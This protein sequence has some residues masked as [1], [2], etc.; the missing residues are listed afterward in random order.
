MK[1]IDNNVF[2]SFLEE[3]IAAGKTV[4][5][6]A[7]GSSMLPFITEDDI[8]YL[9]PFNKTELKK[10]DIILFKYNNNYLLHRII[11]KKNT[12]LLI[13]GDAVANYREKIKIDDVIA[14]LEQI[15][16][17]NGKII[18][19]HSLRWRFLSCMWSILKPFRFLLLKIYKKTILH[20]SK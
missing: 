18:K 11:V 13:Q 14:L 5:I 7:K 19:C 6:R 4:S 17:K 3:E 15:K 9:I 10:N 8:L 20:A 16:K 12:Y 2:F 1:I